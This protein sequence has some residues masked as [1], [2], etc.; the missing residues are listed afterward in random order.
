MTFSWWTDFDP[1]DKEAMAKNQ[2]QTKQWKN[3]VECPKCQGHGGCVLKR[4]AY[5][6]GH[7][8]KGHCDNC[9]GWGTVEAG[10][11]DAMCLHDYQDAGTIGNCLHMWKCS[12]CNKTM[13]VDSSG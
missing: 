5:G 6:K 2:L 1:A 12:K 8:F 10:S 4:D 9:N 7:H 13:E 3:A 11:S